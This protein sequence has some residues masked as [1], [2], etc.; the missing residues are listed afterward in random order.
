MDY[1][2][3][4]PLY[5]Q[6]ITDLKFSQPDDV[7]SRDILAKL[8]K[9]RKVVQINDLSKL[10]KNKYAYVFGAGSSLGEEVKEFSKNYDNR[11][12]KEI[13]TIT[14]DGATTAF[15][16][17][18]V[19]PDIIVT[20]LD[21]F[22][23]DQ[24]KSNENGAIVVVHA[25]G[26]NIAAL[27]EWVPKFKGKII[28][29]TQVEPQEKQ[30]IHN[31]GGFTDGD[32]A[33]FLASHFN[34]RLITLVSFEFTSIGKYSYKYHSKLKFRKL[35]WANLLIGLIKKPKIVYMRPDKIPELD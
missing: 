31:F 13:V 18:D 7:K 22:V 33:V 11:A 6:I 3:W 26:D 28:G 4:K 10:I 1:S 2:E 34:A 29:T 5:D 23:P 17:N 35:T 12:K 24:I 8:L 16:E 32:R 15:I 9:K 25:H 27:K 30:N 14:A 20:D 21:G 19:T